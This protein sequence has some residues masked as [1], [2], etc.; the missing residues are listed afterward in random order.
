MKLINKKENQITF[1]AEME[2]S[3][4]N[5][6]RRYTDQI[7]ILA[8]DDVEISMND[9]PLYDETLAHRLGL[10][11]LK[12][13]KSTS[14][15]R[16]EQL[17]LVAKKEGAVYS[18]ELKGKVKPVHDKIPITLL[19]KEQ[20]LEVLATARM[21]KG[22]EHVKFSP[23]L[24]FYRNALKVKLDKDCMK[25]ISGSLNI[26]REEGNS[27]VIDENEY[28][29]CEILAEKCGKKGKDIEATPT[30]ELLVTI[31]SFGQISEE[32]ILRKAI[33]ALKEDL[34]EVSKKI[35]K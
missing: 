19:K 25:E 18:G 6:I 15:K 4:A 11:P 32:E 30:G 17:T 2:E 12:M 5:A 7:P 34:E 24:L 16:E 9:S 10:I 31:E 29:K 21:G 35:S 28:D 8:I 1:I 26:L 20:E 22:S 27:F 33:E 14:E 13:E 3:L 23:G